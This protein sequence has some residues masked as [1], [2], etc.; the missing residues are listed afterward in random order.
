MSSSSK[1][2]KLRARVVDYA[3]SAWSYLGVAGWNASPFAACIDIDALVLLTGRLGDADARLRDESLDWCASNIAFVS[4]SRIEHLRK[5]DVAG[6]AWA[7]YA[8][9]LQRVTKQRWPGAGAPFEWRASGK[10]RL[11]QR[12]E[13]ATLGLRCRA[14]FGATARSEVLRILLLEG[15]ARAFDAR[16]LAA[17]AAYTKRSIGEALESLAAAGI[18]RSTAVGNSLRFQLARRA[19]LEALLAPLPSVRTSQRAFCRL[20][21]AVLE[22]CE[23]AQSASERVRQVESAR[24]ARTLAA[25]VQRIDPRS[26]LLSSKSLDV[27][28]WLVWSLEQCEVQSGSP[29]PQPDDKPS[30]RSTSRQRRG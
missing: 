12:S 17:E 7:A 21:A 28:E 24:L 29:D 10:S 22:T 18:V 19:E 13:G 4:R 20:V 30:R 14:L 3:W 25:E 9:T 26:T 27:D 6:P 5:D 8:G 15:E 16:D 23:A 2:E 1:L 11:A